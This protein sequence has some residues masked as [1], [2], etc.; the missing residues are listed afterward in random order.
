[1]CPACGA[2]VSEGAERCGECDVRT[3]GTTESF[4]A[5]AETP[6]LAYS[7]DVDSVTSP[8]LVV[9]KGVEVGE[10]FHLDQPEITIGRD[11]ASD[12]FLNDVTVSRQHARLMLADGSV[13]IED[14]G[15]LNGTYVNDSLVESAVLT[16]GDLLQIGRFQ[17]VFLSG[18]AQ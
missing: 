17:M 2:E 16:S 1:M 18:G 4:E 9:R 13:T 11:P 8:V 7:V 6:G 15:S 3:E 10:R 14:A 5:V 12:I